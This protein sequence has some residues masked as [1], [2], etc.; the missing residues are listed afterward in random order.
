M[1][2]SSKIY[3]LFIGRFQPFH[4][5]HEAIVK[6]LL[7]S[8]KNVLIAMR[9]T[10]ID[11]E[12]PYT[13]QERADRIRNYFPDEG[14]VKITSIPDIEEIVYGRDVGYGIRE[15]QLAPELEG[16]SATEIRKLG[17]LRAEQRVATARARRA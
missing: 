13:L 4:E 2:T 17:K 7:A 5:G 3:S 15:V 11:D 10:P 12:N 1:P 14:T 6:D 16:I 9:D 8:G